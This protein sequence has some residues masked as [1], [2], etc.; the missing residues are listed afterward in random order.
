MA[1]SS[2]LTLFMAL[3]CCCSLPNIWAAPF[4][5]VDQ[6]D[7]KLAGKTAIPE[8][9]IV[10]RYPAYIATNE[11]LLLRVPTE[12]IGNRAYR[13]HK[14]FDSL[15]GGTFGKQKRYP[16]SPESEMVYGPTS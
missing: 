8:M 13:I 3:A 7:W 5:E 11:R 2:V 16:F 6:Q 15:S 14:K 4:E 12:V 9:S 1:G 10:N